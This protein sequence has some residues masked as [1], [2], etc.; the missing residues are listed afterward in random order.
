MASGELIVWGYSSRKLSS[1]WTAARR[2]GSVM[3]SS[4]VSEKLTDG[5]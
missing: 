4:E 1:V 2:D 3:A 5:C